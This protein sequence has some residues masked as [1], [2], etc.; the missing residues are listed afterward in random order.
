MSRHVLGVVDETVEVSIDD[1]GIVR[2]DENDATIF[3]TSTG[4]GRV[5]ELVAA[6]WPAIERERIE[7]RWRDPAPHVAR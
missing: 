1:Y 2:L 6:A 4:A 3:L 5:G 7:R